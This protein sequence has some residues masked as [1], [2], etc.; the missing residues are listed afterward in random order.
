[1]KEVMI[2]YILKKNQN[3]I[4]NSL[5]YI[6]VCINNKLSKPIVLYRGKSGVYIFID[7]IFEEYDYSKKVMHEHF[8]KNFVMSIEDEKRFQSINKCWVC[9]KLFIDEDKKVGHHDHIT[10]RYRGS[11]LSDCNIN[12][13]L[14]KNV[15]V[16]FHNLRGYDSHLI[17]QK[18]DKFDVKVDVIPNGLEKY[19][20]FIINKSLVFIDR[21]RFMNSSLDAL[22]KNLTDN[23]SKNLPQEFNGEQLNLVKQKGVYPYEYM[24]SFKKFSEDKLPDRC[25]FY[26]SLK[27][28]RI[29][30][31]DKCISEKD[32]HISEEDHL[33][34]VN[35]WKS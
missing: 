35:V 13:K 27:D 6:V 4:P 15:L 20:A 21:M 2:L 24:E 17:M 7:E 18:I 29:N 11:A 1:M 5:A 9:N 23:D 16:T 31:K 26:S 12:L 10:G 8:N 32:G 22:V 25:E 33:H 3:H 14:T 28:G 19:M 34:T 30:E